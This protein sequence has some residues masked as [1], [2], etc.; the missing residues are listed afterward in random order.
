MKKDEYI[1]YEDGMRV[2]LDENDVPELTEE[3]FKNAKPF[4]ALPPS[5]QK[6]LKAIQK[7]GRPKSKAPKEMIAFR[8]APDLLA[9]IRALGKG[10]N[11]RVEKLLREALEHGL[12]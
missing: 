11:A 5:L 3:W 1:E 12:L 6:K 9:S 2:L 8:F 7:R 4:S 10:Y